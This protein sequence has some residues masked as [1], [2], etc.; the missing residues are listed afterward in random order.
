MTTEEKISPRVISIFCIIL[1]FV[2]C[3]YVV[4][5]KLVDILYFLTV[6]GFMIKYIKLKRMK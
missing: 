5:Y 4:S 2:F 1:G 6:L 3:S